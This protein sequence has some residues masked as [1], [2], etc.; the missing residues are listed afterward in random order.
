MNKWKDEIGKNGDE[1]SASIKIGCLN[2][3]VSN[4]HRNYKGQ[5]IVRSSLAVVDFVE[6]QATDLQSA[7]KEALALIS[8][9]AEIILQELKNAN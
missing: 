4:A 1:A 3:F 9:H 7:K 2:V 8:E 5:W 6:L